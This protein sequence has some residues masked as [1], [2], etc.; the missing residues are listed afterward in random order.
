MRQNPRDDG[1]IRT[2]RTAKQREPPALTLKRA[3]GTA[4]NAT[5]S[6]S[7]FESVVDDSDMSSKDSGK[8]DTKRMAPGAVVASKKGGID[9]QKLS[10][11]LSSSREILES[12]D[13]YGTASFHEM[14]EKMNDIGLFER[15][16]MFDH[17]YE[18]LK[19]VHDGRRLQYSAGPCCASSPADSC[20]SHPYAPIHLC[21]FLALAQICSLLLL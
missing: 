3:E 13:P 10:Q 9:V 12:V 18:S 5:K 2:N 20:F 17:T 14:V 6:S 4:T 11:H 15:L 8:A 7:A 21:S 19:W 1:V 16:R